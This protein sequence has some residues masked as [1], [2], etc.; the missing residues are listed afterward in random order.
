MKN[1]A[2]FLAARRLQ[3]TERAEDADA[4]V[5]INCGA[6]LSDAALYRESRI[7]PS[8]RF[9][10]SLGAHRRIELLADPGSFRESNRSLISVDPLN[11]RAQVRYRRRFQEEERR[12]GLADAAVTGS[13]LIAGRRVA[14]AALD[15]RFLGGSIGCAAGEKLARAFEQAARN[16]VPLVTIVA[17][18]GVRMQEGVLALLQLAKLIEAASRLAAA[19][20]PHIVVL[21]NP[22]MGGA[23]AVL[24]NTADLVLA[25]PGALIGY[26][27]TRMVEEAAGRQTPEGARTAEHLLKAGMI[28]HIVDRERLRDF[29]TS[30]LEL[31]AARPKP[32][33]ADGP[34]EARFSPGEHNAWTTIQLARHSGR[35][36]ATDYIAHFSDSFVELRGDR[37]S[38]DD[39]AVVAGIGMLGAEP[40]VYIGG[41]RRRGG[42]TQTEVRPEGFRKARR[43][44]ELAARLRLPVVSLID[45]VTASAALQAD[46]AG[47]GTALAGSMAAFAAAVTPIVGAVIGEA[48]G[49]AAVALGIADRLLMLQNA[50]FE[51]VSPEA[52]ASILYRD[53]G[54][55]D[56]V[57]PA[58][59]PTARDC[60]KLHIVDSVVPEPAAGAHADHD[61]AARLLSAALLRAI[62][63]LKGTSPR[64]LVRS[65]Y[66]R[67]RRMG[68]YT[69]FIR[70]TVSRDVAQLGGEIARRATGAISRL[71]RRSAREPHAAPGAGD[72]GES[73]LVP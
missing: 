2:E 34:P 51:V 41:E 27:T 33:A 38:G 59:R 15:F 12:T 10:Y 62:G 68:Q 9:H 44:V 32:G 35:P 5:C 29:L 53:T 8:C 61:A 56:S 23:Y 66:D 70:E 60:L 43:A 1:L 20:E 21:A 30:L 18:G 65:R 58:L 4:A 19:G 48:R 24:G 42:E 52:A 54:M 64:K 71:T 73:L 16:H 26:A 67:Y 50:A 36:T 25:E 6:D 69:N 45:G 13:C 11:F 49:E 28:D 63:E 39:R 3:D 37:V 55:A 7:C 72:D 40:V 46:T 31:L 47:L 17:S 14:I 22:S 57:A